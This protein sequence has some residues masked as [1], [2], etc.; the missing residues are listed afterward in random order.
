MAQARKQGT[1]TAAH[2]QALAE[3][4]EQSRVVRR[5]LEA[6][7]RHRPRRGRK[8]AP[9]SIRKRLAAIDASLAGDVAPLK[10]L[11]LRQERMD[12]QAEL[13]NLDAKADLADLEKGFVKVAKG[14]AQRK[15]ISYAAWR[16][17]GVPAE[18]LS[19]AGIGRSS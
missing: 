11:Q 16:E 5:Y 8:R 9:D 7:Q 12:L 13:A 3:G 4:R 18:V 19:R 1:M 14:Y 10:E 17:L 6:L 2:K 15:G